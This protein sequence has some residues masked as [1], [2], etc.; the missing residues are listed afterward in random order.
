M[1]H[2]D[3]VLAGGQD[4]MDVAFTVE[5]DVEEGLGFFACGHLGLVGAL[6][7]FAPETVGH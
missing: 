3:H 5:K 6:T 1:V 7:E 2:I 4:A